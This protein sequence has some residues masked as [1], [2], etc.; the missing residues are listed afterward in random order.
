MKPE[1]AVEKTKPDSYQILDRIRSHWLSTLAHDLSGPLF[2]ARGYTRLALE[3]KDSPLTAPRRKY[4]TSV[5]ENIN[6]LV[7]LAQE[8]SD[9]PANEGFEFET[10]SFRTLLQQVTAEIRSGLAEKGIT[11]TEHFSDSP[12]TTIGD[13]EKLTEAVRGFLLLAVELAG[14]GGTVKV[15]AL[16]ENEKIILRFFPTRGDD[17]RETSLPD[18]SMPCKLWRLHGG[19]TSVSRSPDSEYLVACEL[20]VIRQFECKESASAD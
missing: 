7:T 1:I 13:R 18:F 4:L 17:S 8:L 14:R 5:L 2:A 19:A 10:V 6:R 20:P 16:E 3:E 15:Q 9:F 12:L 11:L